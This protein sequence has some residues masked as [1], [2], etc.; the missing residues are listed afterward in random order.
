MK[1]VKKPFIAIML[2]TG[3]IILTG[4][5]GLYKMK[6]ETGKMNPCNSGEIINNIYAVKDS[7]VNLYLVKN[8][9]S[10]IAIDAGISLKKVEE[11]MDKLGIAP[12]KVIAV[13]LTHSDSDHTGAVK[14]FKNAKVYISTAEEQM[15]NGKTVRT[16]YLFKNKL[17]VP[18][19]KIEDNQ[20]ISLSGFKVKGILTPGHTPG[21]MSYV[22]NG[23]SLFTGD[24][25]SLQNGN[26]ELFN[27]FF[28]MDSAEESK[29]IKKISEL[30]GINYIFTAHYGYSA[31]FSEAIKN[32]KNK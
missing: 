27:E 30:N 22:V 1:S 13:F 18:Y 29:S 5:V 12:E 26:A 17:K 31:D 8:N 25:L 20:E 32:W 23:T 19:D 15:I 3:I 14:L 28:N 11:E 6:S 7:F 10:Y 2:I 9:D 4:I 16:M 24:T 21:S